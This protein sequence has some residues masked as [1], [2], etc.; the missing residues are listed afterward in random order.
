MSLPLYEEVV[1]MTMSIPLSMM[2]VAVGH[3]VHAP[4]Q[5][6]ARPTATSQ[7]SLPARQA[8]TAEIRLLATGP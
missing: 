4:M 2:R 3:L 7:T 1:Y 5:R 8:E 6:D